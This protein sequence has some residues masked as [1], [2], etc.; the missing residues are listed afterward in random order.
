MKLVKLGEIC[1]FSRGLTY[2][3]GDEVD[4]SNNVVLRANNID[5]DTN[6]L[7]LE[8]LRYIKD[9][10]QIKNEKI[11]KKNSIIIC[12]ASGS[13]THVGKVALIEEDY[14]YAFGGFMGQLIPTDECHPKFLY[15]VLTSAVFK[16]FLMSLNDG[17]NINNLK[18]SDIE[19]FA[20]LLP[21]IDKQR[22]LVEKID[23]AFAEIELLEVNLALCDSNASALQM[24]LLSAAFRREEAFSESSTT[25]TIQYDGYRTCKIKDLFRVGSSKR[26]LKSDWKTSG[27]PFFRGRE[28]S[29]LSKTGNAENE[30]FISEEHYIELAKNYGV[31]VVGDIMITAI[32]TIGN[33]HIVKA[34]DRFYFK[35]ASVLWLHNQKDANAKFVD[36]FLKSELFFDQLDKGNGAT[37]DTLT[38]EK[39]SNVSINIPSLEKQSEIVARL[40]TAFLEIEKMRNQIGVQKDF[41]GMLRQ[42]LLSEA[43]SGTQEMVT[44]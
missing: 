21:S 19:N 2:N 23:N 36:Y 13:K 16:K 28:I 15:Y 18:F 11:A 4:F 35:D 6:S 39:L 8:N 25:P 24:S 20:I 3:K 40:D 41:V 32:G 12:T 9:S 22:E 14:G 27:V 30:L 7:N 5:L 10:I 29:R 1:T 26:V 33:T 17:T 42:S 38:I 43:F 44:A 34:D 37:V 31:P